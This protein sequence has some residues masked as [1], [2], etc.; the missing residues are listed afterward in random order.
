MQQ[1]NHSYYFCL[2]L[3]N[4]KPVGLRTLLVFLGGS[5]VASCQGI[6]WGFYFR[7]AFREL[8]VLEQLHGESSMILDR[9]TAVGRFQCSNEKYLE[10]NETTGG[11]Q[12]TGNLDSIN[13]AFSFVDINNV[14][15]G[16]SGQYW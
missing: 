13:T 1:V 4:G 6:A 12:C 14:I 8:Q 5:L 16:N 2:Y 7:S 11:V 10:L 9:T 3:A 15:G